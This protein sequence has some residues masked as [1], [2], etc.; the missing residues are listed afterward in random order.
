MANKRGAARMRHPLFRL[1]IRAAYPQDPH[2][3]FRFDDADSMLL[4]LVEVMKHFGSWTGRQGQPFDAGRRVDAGAP[5]HRVGRHSTA[6]S[7]PATGAPG[8]HRRMGVARRSGSPSPALSHA[9]ARYL[10]KVQ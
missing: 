10:C 3:A 8:T 7:G 5:L 9:I 4:I 1:A 2:G 6:A